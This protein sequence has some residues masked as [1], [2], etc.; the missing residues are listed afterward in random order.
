MVRNIIMK[1]GNDV[2]LACLMMAYIG[3]GCVDPPPTGP[4]LEEAIQEFKRLRNEQRTVLCAC[5]TTIVNAS[6]DGY[7]E[8]EQEC[9]DSI[10]LVDDENLDCMRGVLA[11]IHAS[12]TDSAK[13]IQCYNEAYEVFN[14]CNAENVQACSGSV[15]YECHQKKQNAVEDCHAALSDEQIESLFLCTY[16]WP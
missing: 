12:E 9:L 11:E 13:L 10:G 4:S 15:Q 5:P 16:A 2:S 3:A 6:G 8:S 1:F 14:R 7:Y